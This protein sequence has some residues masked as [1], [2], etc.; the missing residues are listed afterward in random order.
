VRRCP[1]KPSPPAEQ[2]AQLGWSR[3]RI[4][5]VGNTGAGKTT[6]FNLVC[7]VY[8]P[9]QGDI[10]LEC[11]DHAYSS[12][13]IEWVLYN[14]EILL[15]VL[16]HRTS[17]NRSCRKTGHLHSRCFEAKREGKDRPVLELYPASDQA[18]IIFPAVGL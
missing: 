13:P 8:R 9:T 2:A 3:E 10:R 5:V 18:V 7:G 14:R 17:S 16:F 1:W 11:T 12:T 4:I 15:I 6:V